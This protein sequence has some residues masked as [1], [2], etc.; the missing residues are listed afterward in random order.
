MVAWLL[1]SGCKSG[2]KE[3]RHDSPAQQSNPLKETELNTITLTDKAVERLDVQTSAVEQKDMDNIRTWSGEVMAEPGKGIILT[4]PV[5]GSVLAPAGHDFVRAGQQVK[6]G[7]LLYRLLI[8]P[9]E[10]DLIS[11]QSDVA[12][13]RVQHEVAVQK[14]ERNKQLLADKAGSQRTVQESEAELAGITASLSVAEARVE[15]LKGNKTESVADR[16]STLDV[17]A[18]MTGIVQQVYTSSTQVVAT[19]APIMEIAELSKVWIKVAVY[20]GDAGRIDDNALAFVR[21][22]SEFG[23]GNQTEKA[24]PVKAPQTANGLTNSV[25]MYY[26]LQNP[27]RHFRPGQKIN[28]TLAYKGHHTSLIVPFSAVVYDIYG[29][30]WV[31][32][33]TEPQKYVRRRV[34]LEGTRDGQALIRQGI[35]AGIKVVTVGAAELFGIEFGGGK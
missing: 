28:V 16:L 6:K 22:L 7:D 23:K 5:A 18:P 9:S 24:Y 2:S 1:L 30:T 19:A 27:D 34:E 10:K 25:D 15:L 31:Y 11:A 12:Q 20:A 13:K 33:N 32:E 14:A 35:S 8:L 29:G 26:E 21:Q 17:R 4:A 3:V